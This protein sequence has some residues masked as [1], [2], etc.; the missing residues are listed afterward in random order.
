MGGFRNGKTLRKLTRV[1]GRSAK[2]PPLPPAVGGPIK[3]KPSKHAK[4]RRVLT[5]KGAPVAPPPDQ[6]Q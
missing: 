2:P 4:A 5:K 6:T 1:V 3:W